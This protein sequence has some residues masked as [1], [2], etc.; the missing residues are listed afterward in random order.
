MI[1]VNALNNLRLVLPEDKQFV[2]EFCK[3][4]LDG[5]TITV[6]LLSEKSRFGV[7]TKP[8]LIIKDNIFYGK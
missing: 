4:E 6:T 5:D 3:L 8:D 7:F 2:I 1:T